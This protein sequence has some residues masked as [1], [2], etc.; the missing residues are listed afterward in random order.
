[1]RAKLLKFCAY[2]NKAITQWKRNR[3]CSNE[4]LNGFRETHCE[5][6]RLNAPGRKYCRICLD[7]KG[8]A[9]RILRMKRKQESGLTSQ[10]SQINQ[11]QKI[12]PEDKL[13]GSL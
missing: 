5:C 11:S 7:K 9:M 4:C 1:M 13:V 8:R 12:E 2:C 3:Y 10:Q 6:G